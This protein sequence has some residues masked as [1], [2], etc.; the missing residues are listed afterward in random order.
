M[1]DLQFL[2]PLLGGGG[3]KKIGSLLRPPLSK[4]LKPRLELIKMKTFRSKQKP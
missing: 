1:I 3:G 4:S 2:I